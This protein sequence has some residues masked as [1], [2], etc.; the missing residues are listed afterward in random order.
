VGK[1]QIN[2]VI[3]VIKGSA[4]KVKGYIYKSIAS[5]RYTYI[6]LHKIGKYKGILNNSLIIALPNGVCHGITQRVLD[7]RVK[8]ARQLSELIWTCLSSWIN[9]TKIYEIIGLDHKQ[10]EGLTNGKEAFIFPISRYEGMIRALLIY[11]KDN[12]DRVNLEEIANIVNVPIE[13]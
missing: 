3:Y 10:I 12:G 2:G 7:E 4:G 6:P 11:L 9:P 8:K 13:F 1:M 5:N